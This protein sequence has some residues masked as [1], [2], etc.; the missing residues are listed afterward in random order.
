MAERREINR[1]VDA[2]RAG[3]RHA[4][5]ELFDRFYGSSR[6]RPAAVPL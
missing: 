1:L 5:G 3:D 2:A 4:F 6:N